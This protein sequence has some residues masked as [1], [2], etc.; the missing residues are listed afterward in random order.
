MKEQPTL[1]TL[2]RRAVLVR[3][4]ALGTALATLELVGARAKVPVRAPLS[5]RV[6]ATLPDI[7]FDVGAYISQVQSIDGVS[8]QFGPVNTTFLTARLLR[9]PTKSDQSMLSN[10]LNTIE[11]HYPFSA[12]GI[13]TFISYGL[14]Y[15][16]RLPRSVVSANVPHLL[17]DTSRSVLEEAVPSPTDVSSQNPG[18]VKENFNVPV[19]I[20]GN[21]MLFTIR[22]DNSDYL[23]DVISWLG[24]SNTLAGQSVAS[25]ALSGLLAF[26]SSRAMFQQMGL[27][28]YVAANNNLPYADFIDPHSPM[29]MGFADQQ[30]HGSG[31]AAICTFAGN[32]S[33]HLTTAKAGSYFDN[34]SIQHLAHDILDLAQFFDL[35]ATGTPGS[36]GTYTE[37]VQYMFRSTPPPSLGNADQFSNGGGPG[38]LENVFQGTDD[39]LNS[40]QGIGT[41]QHEHRIGH[42]SQLQRSSRAADGTPI[43]VRMD[44]PGF[45]N[46]DVPDGSKQPKLQFTVFVPS[47]DF[48]QTMRRNQASLDLAGQFAVAQQDNGLE[49]F[50]TATRRQNFLAPPRR[51]RAFPLLE[52][53]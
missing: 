50:I 45:D 46:L 40:A 26:T 21:D 12:P 19:K 9:N 33:A 30:V 32:S 23:A 39:A 3:A 25:P 8:F 6:A 18:V 53:T 38:F 22:G 10:A 20:E 17:T 4:G 41:P 52:L 43:H 2:T 7:Q 24:G 28:R 34:G 11:S 31:P 51:H 35:D 44:G 15:F 13:F 37:R 14:P 1:P 49:R 36:D 47:A 42:L 48:F 29:W 16:N 5:A 27:P